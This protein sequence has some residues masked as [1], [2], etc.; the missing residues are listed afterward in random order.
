MKAAAVLNGGAG[1]VDDDDDDNG[2][3]DRDRDDDDQEVGDAG[4]AGGAPAASKKKKKKKKRNKKKA[5]GDPAA[6]EAGEE[7]K[8]GGPRGATAAAAPGQP[9]KRPPHLGLKETAFTD[10]YVRLGQTEPPTVPVQ[11]LFRAAGKELPS[12]EVLPHPGSRGQALREPSAEARAREHLHED[13][14]AKVRLGAEVHRQVRAYAQ[15]LMKPG[16]LLADLCEKLENKNRELVREQ[17]IARG[18]GFP[19]GCSLNNV[20]A[21]YTPN[22]GDGTVL[23]YDDVMKVTHC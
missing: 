1:G 15:S 20:A 4:S 12:G 7:P 18:I 16:V 19:T 8:E 11:D 9:S 13:L 5:G 17:G 21:H 14:L 10:Y 2:V 23:K 22:A 3:D 6:A